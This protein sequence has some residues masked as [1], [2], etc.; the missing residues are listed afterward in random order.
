SIEFVTIEA[1]DTA[2]AFYAEAF[3]LGV[4]LRVRDSSAPTTGF[5]GFTV[6]LIV[7]QPANADALIDAALVGGAKTLKP[8][9]KSLWGYGG[10]V[11]A[12]DG[13]I[14]T[15]ASSSKK[16]TA[17][18]SRQVDD[19]VLQLGVEDVAATKQFYIDRGLAVTKRYGRKYVEFGDPASPVKLSLYKRRAL[20]K[21]AGVA[22]EGSGFAPARHRWRRRLLHR[23]RR[24]RLGELELFVSPARSPGSVR[25]GVRATAGGR[26]AAAAS[27]LPDL[28]PAD[29]PALEAVVR[30]PPFPDTGSLSPCANRFDAGEVEGPFPSVTV[31]GGK[32]IDESDVLL[33]VFVSR[34]CGVVV[35]HRRP[36]RAVTAPR[37]IE[38]VRR[39]RRSRW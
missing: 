39:R 24:L 35:L 32:G 20:A 25:N 9:A 22:P 33:V 10:V 34:D 14:W 17:S 28:Q 19:I 12:P 3:D 7:S 2:A 30:F 27:V 6:S 4:R 18:A 37:G 8:A 13:T 31:A 5:R 23:P 11:Q 26:A 15:V 29:L 21:V 36:L 38:E 16:D 1:D